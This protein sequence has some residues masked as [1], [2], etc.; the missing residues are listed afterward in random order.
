MTKHP[1]DQS[2]N[3]L[4][5]VNN[6]LKISVNNFFTEFCWCTDNKGKHF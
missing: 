4:I 2:G 3:N 5:K 6:A 1:G